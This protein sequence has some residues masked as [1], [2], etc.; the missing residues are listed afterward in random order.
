M[1]CLLVCFLCLSPPTDLRATDAPNDAGHTIQLDWVKSIDDMG[2]PS[3]SGYDILRGESPDGPFENVGH[4]PRLNE[5]FRDAS[6]EDGRPYYYKVALVSDSSEVETAVVGPVSSKP[7]WFHSGRVNVLI[8]VLIYTGLLVFF[9]YGA[10][11]GKKLY[12]RPISGLSAVDE[13]VGRATEMG[14]PILYVPG[15]SP[16]RPPSTKPG[17]SSP[18]GTRWSTPWQEK[19]SRKPAMRS[20]DRTPLILP[21][22]STSPTASSD[23]RPPWTGS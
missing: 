12:L 6:V 18:I 1:V 17:S 15:L 21:A 5:T 2:S 10:K 22:C 7:Q 11:K 19:W 9:I 3:I 23:T 14:K 8:G 4:V 20:G 13:A 16:R